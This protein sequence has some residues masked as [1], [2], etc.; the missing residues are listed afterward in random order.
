MWA[1]RPVFIS[2]TFLD[3]HAERD[4]LRRFVFPALEERLRARR[5]HLEWVDLR[6]G[7]ASAGESD[8]EARETQVLKVCL[9][10]VHR[11]RPFLLVLVGDRYGWSPPRERIRAVAKEAGLHFATEGCSVTE[12]EIEYGVLAIAAHKV[13]AVVYFR[14]P[15]PYQDMPREMREAF[16]EADSDNARRLLQL[17]LRIVDALP[18]QV[19]TYALRWDGG[20][21][22]FAGL[23]EW[24]HRILEDLWGALTVDVEDAAAVPVSWQA[25]ERAALDA[26]IEQRGRDF[27]GRRAVVDALLAHATGR[28]A[29]WAIGVTGEAGAGKSALFSALHRRLSGAGGVLLLAHAAGASPRAASL[30][31]MLRRWIDEL[32]EA[33]DAAVDLAEDATAAAVERIFAGLL[34]RACETRRVVV[35]IDALDQFEAGV[36]MQYMSWLPAVWPANARLVA[37]AIAGEPTSALVERGARLQPLPGLDWAESAAIVEAVCARY[38][39]TLEPEV[40][41]ALLA[42]SAAAQPL[43]LVL[44]A[45]ELNLIDADDLARAAHRY[46]G[47]PAERLRAMMVDRA[48]NLPGDVPGLYAASFDHAEQLFGRMFAVSFVGLLAL[49]RGGWRELDFRVLIPQLT[50]ETWDEL[51]FAQLRRIFRG[52]IAQ[53]GA[54]AQWNCVHAQMRVAARVRLAATRLSEPRLHALIAQHLLSLPADDP[55][56]CAE[57]M[58]HLMM[59]A[60]WARAAAYFGDE[61]LREA[62]LSG[63]VLAV[64][65]LVADAPEGDDL[66]AIAA[67]LAAFDPADARADIAVRRCLFDARTLLAARAGNRTQRMFFDLVTQAAD[68]LVKARPDSGQRRLA[69][70]NAHLARGILFAEAGDRPAARAALETALNI[71]VELNTENPTDTV[72][73]RQVL[74]VQQKLADV[75][76]EEGRLDAVTRMR[77]TSLA[78]AKQLAALQPDD[79]EVRHELAA[80]QESIAQSLVASA[81]LAGAKRFL[82]EAVESTR[83]LAAQNPG[84]ALLIEHEAIAL[85]RLAELQGGDNEL[86]MAETSVRTA[87]GILET[88]VAQ[89]PDARSSRAN[90]AIATSTLGDLLATRMDFAGAAHAYSRARESLERLTQRDPSNAE[91]QRSLGIACFQQAKMLL[92]K[93]EHGEAATAIEKGLSLIA[94]LAA[95]DP[96][97]MQWTRDLAGL[98]GLRGDQ[99]GAADDR[100][101]AQESYAEALRLTERWAKND[102]STE[103]QRDLARCHDA[104]GH[105]LLA[106][107]DLDG[108]EVSFR[109][110]MGIMASLVERDEANTG[111]RRDLAGIHQSMAEVAKAR[112]DWPAAT[113]RQVLATNIL[114]DVATDRGDNF[115]AQFEHA[116]EL[117]QLGKSQLQSGDFRMAAQTLRRALDVTALEPPPEMRE[118]YAELITNAYMF[119]G[120]ALNESEPAEA[121]A[122]LREAMA[123]IGGWAEREP[124]RPDWR[125]ALASVGEDL[126]QALSATGDWNGAQ[127]VYE[128]AVEAWARLSRDRDDVELRRGLARSQLASARCLVSRGDI[129]GAIRA[130]AP[131]RTTLPQREREDTANFTALLAYFEFVH[132][133]GEVYLRNSQWN[134]V[135]AL[136]AEAMPVAERVIARRPDFDTL[137]MQL[138]QMAWTRAQVMHKNG[139]HDAAVGFRRRTRDELRALASR[140]VPLGDQMAALLR[141]LEERG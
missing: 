30:D 11:C 12:L 3:M 90:L 117:V 85:T 31:L 120:V 113:R 84:N 141:K 13:R 4:H 52:Q 24:G 122:P 64:V 136:F 29:N 102:D 18:D 72:P 47:A 70:S 111:W 57:A 119:L 26:F 97:N 74:I 22:R 48:G 60:D 87:V 134:E 88:L 89:H 17:K 56:R 83:A 81:D 75:L 78:I 107:K 38:H 16:S 7:V 62:E 114:Q 127:P 15:L 94:P 100:R 116:R 6:V 80:A 138:V 137:R 36:R 23:E 92:A 50:G 140:G 44:A 28:S 105:A 110:G 133:L 101:G 32:S 82:R 124:D 112:R 132:V 20:S 37:T 128:V 54:Q 108:A 106:D 46:D 125:R 19:R 126:A 10:E 104:L 67:L 8:L 86:A 79:A 9:A 96:S 27:I 53:T 59:S 66:K 109:A 98:H 21:G 25:E 139:R 131:A 115:R 51:R 63:A 43:W 118:A 73:L 68:R 34:A 76:A 39:R 130:A 45:E 35:L 1:S 95:R 49:G 103:A 14:D 58:R 135:E 99:R 93:G 33:V 71:V 61:S 69:L 42:H 5:L 40:T 129:R 77:R 41:G 55:L 65:D 91:W 121:V 2:S 123:F